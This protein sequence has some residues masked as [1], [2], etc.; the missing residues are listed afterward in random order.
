[1]TSAA[2]FVER[3]RVSRRPSLEEM[4]RLM[5]GA[6][7]GRVEARSMDTALR[8]AH[9]VVSGSSCFIC[10]RKRMG[11]GAVV[12]WRPLDVTALT[13]GFLGCAEG[14]AEHGAVERRP[15]R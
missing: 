15:M 3:F 9:F 5:H 7:F 8:G 2:K 1:M 11:H 13:R 12:G 10:Y 14:D 4:K 6:R